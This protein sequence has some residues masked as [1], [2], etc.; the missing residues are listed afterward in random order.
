MGEITVN[1]DHQDD[2]QEDGKSSSKY[3]D[4]QSSN[5]TEELFRGTNLDPIYWNRRTEILGNSEQ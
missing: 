5:R 3:S 2:K 1:N 4:V